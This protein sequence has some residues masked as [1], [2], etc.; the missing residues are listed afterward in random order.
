MGVRV[1]EITEY[2]STEMLIKDFSNYKLGFTFIKIDKN[3][4]QIFIYFLSKCIKVRD[5]KKQYK[6]LYSKKILNN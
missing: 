3:I 6:I 5:C 4:N 2:F 1:T